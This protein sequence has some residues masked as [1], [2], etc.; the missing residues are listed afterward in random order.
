MARIYVTPELGEAIKSIRV[1]NKITGKK[2]A[3]HINKSS[4]FITRLES[5]SIE[6]VDEDD[7][8]A[9]FEFI[10]KDELDQ[11]ETIERIYD[12]LKIKYSPEDI[13]KQVW[14]ENFDTVIRQIPI[15]EELVNEINE[16]I[17]KQ[18]IEP[19]YLLRRINANE[20]LSDA[21]VNDDHPYNTWW[22]RDDAPTNATS[23]KIK[24]TENEFY[25]ILSKKKDTTSY[26]FMLAIA[27]Y[28]IKIE[29]FNEVIKFESDID[30]SSVMLEADNLLNKYKF[31]TIAV[32]EQLIANAKTKSEFNELLSHF[33]IDNIEVVNSIL[34]SIRY[35]SDRNIKL[36]NDQLILFDKNINWDIGFMLKLV[37]LDFNS[38]ENASH[39]CKSELIKK[40]EQ[41]IT[42]TN[43]MSHAEKTIEIY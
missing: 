34:K 42:E 16:R 14:F 8:W 38:I 15:P 27:F 17:V 5:A 32:R 21:E 40:I 1:Q 24:L 7:L 26:I 4:A 9:I 29:K 33:E 11:N 43:Q 25:D 37:S 12:T 18:N 2:L 30:H 41:L 10:C 20:D 28:L 13:K 35:Y 36:A 22:A 23:I 6:T 31:H 19:S 3:E 39:S